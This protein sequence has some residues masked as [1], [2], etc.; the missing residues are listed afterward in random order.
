VVVVLEVAV[1]PVGTAAVCGPTAA[2]SMQASVEGDRLTVRHEAGDAIQGPD[3]LSLVVGGDAGW[4]AVEFDRARASYPVGAGDAWVFENLPVDGRPPGQGDLV[5]VRFRARD[6]PPDRP[7]HCYRFATN[8]YH[9]V[10]EQ[11]LAA[12]GT[13]VDV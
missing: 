9:V 8:Q 12:D 7:W 2:V 6:S 10:D 4:T 3:R 5:R 11:R 13:G 1:I